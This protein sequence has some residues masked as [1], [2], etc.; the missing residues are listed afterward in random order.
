[1]TDA[2]SPFL[3]IGIRYDDFHDN[4]N[5]PLLSEVLKR[6]ESGRDKLLLQFLRK[7]GGIRSGPGP[8]FMSK[9]LKALNTSVV[10]I[11]IDD[12]IEELDW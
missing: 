12:K 11:E 10:E 2:L 3:K 7:E 9:E 6:M 1:L 8:L 4:G 5:I